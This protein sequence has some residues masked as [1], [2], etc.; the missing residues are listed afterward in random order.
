MNP[1]MDYTE[2]TLVEKPAI[3][4][5]EEL[6]WTPFNAFHEFDGGLSSLGR[7]NKSEV[8]L[9]SRLREA[10][11]VLNPDAA[12]EAIH[13]AI[14]ELSRD[15]SRLSMVAANR[16]VYELLKSGV[17]V[18]VPDPEG[19]GESVEVIRVMDWD[20]PGNNDFLVCSQFWITGEMHTRRADLVGFVNGLPLVL[21]ELKAVHRRLETAFTGN[22]RDYKDTI[23]QLFWP[24]ALV[25]LSNGSQS[26][27]GS[28]T[29]GWEHFAEWKKVDS[30]DEPARVSLETMLRGVCDPDRLLD[31]VE[32][33]TLFQEAPGGLIKLTAKNHQYLGVN[34]AI[35]ALIATLSPALSPALSQGERGKEDGENPGQKEKG[36]GHYRGGYDF[37][38]LVS[39]ARELRQL[40]TPAE[41][42]LWV[43]LR[44]KQL[45]G[46]KFRRQHQIG[47]YIVDFYCHAAKLIIE[48]DGS[49]HDVPEKQ[50]KDKKKQAYLKGLG[51]K[52][53]RIPNASILDSPHKALNLIVLHLPSPP[54]RGA[55]GEGNTAEKAKGRLGVFWHTQGSGKSVSMMFFT[56]KVLRKI[57]GN[58]TFVVVTDRLELDGQIYKHFATSGVVTESQAQAE[59]SR[60]LRQLLGEDHRFVFTIINKFRTERGE[61]HPV[62][63]ERDDIIVI[64]DEA[65]RSQYDTMALNMRT[66][67][68]KASF[69][70][71]TGTPLI[72]GEEKTRLVFGDYISVYDFQ[73]SVADG[74]T[75]PL[76]Y[77][78]RIPELQLT[79]AN[80][81]ADM[82]RLLEEAELDEAQEKKLERDFAREYHL[83]TREDRLE[84]IAKD[85]VN[86]FSSRGFRGKG[87]MIC[88]DKATAI[89]MYDKVRNHWDAK[90][91]E[92]RGELDGVNEDDRSALDEDVLTEMEQRIAWMR[93]TDMA[94]VV[95]QGQN[96]IAEMVAKGLDIKPH[97][98]RMLDEDLETRFKKPDDPLRLVF[99]CAMWITGFDVPSCSTLYLDKPMR[100]HTLMQTIARAN[101]VFFGK[102]C[103]LIVDYVGVFRNLEKALAIYGSKGSSGTDKSEDKKPVEDKSALV[104]ALRHALGETE[105]MCRSHGI[106]LDAIRAADGLNCVGLLD[107]AV[108]A[109]V[110]TEE[111]KR[112]YLDLANVVQRL[113]KAVLPDPEAKEFAAQV[114][115]IQVIAEK[116]RDLTPPADISLIMEQVEDL[117]D[118]S[119]ATEGYIIHQTHPDYGEENWVDLSGIDFDA[120][121]EKFKKGRKRTINEKLKGTLA[122]KL[123]AMLRLNP[124]RMDYLEKFQAMIDDYNK[125]SLNAEEFFHR[126]KTFAGNLTHEEQR[127]VSEQLTEEELTLFDL[128]T[129]PDIELSEKD[130]IKVKAT[131]RQLLEALKREKL[132]LDWRKRQQARAEV[133]VTIEKVLD[134]GLPRVYTP[135]LF[136]QKSSAVYQHVYDAYFGDGG[137]VYGTAA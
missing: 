122:R 14:A 45:F 40:Q 15:R 104:A 136:N 42:I 129:K 130:K 98:K 88:I 4:L 86:H 133:R 29:A 55:G 77:E 36:K 62:L 38:G 64:T 100:N 41:E 58:W 60:H 50:T 37:G 6:G 22:L 5:L 91:A 127:A 66:A 18:S 85:L 49:I 72:V 43:F 76:Y 90:I 75:V 107:D 44:S 71:F 28:I 82:E 39:R 125:G 117:L 101:R 135:E 24:N 97:R 30:E 8:I 112:G 103:G 11:L 65:H 2:D 48:V 17:R 25:I 61:T 73:Q 120:L 54:G 26:R 80:L 94:V 13:E 52:I 9:K 95:S 87:M 12:P 19:D 93:E 69:L 92:L 126:L 119:V 89:R 137:S 78:N 63:S 84:A 128:L 56:Q 47:D 114:M 35:A 115:P 53:I 116:I 23:P 20:V 51:Y 1:P 99:V 105:R 59:S 68:P 102:V 81:N 124:T 96:E 67:L 132:V 83:I 106:H 110:G 118:R 34:N 10:L 109:L 108:D 46:Y 131:A 3:A 33:F 123:M 134:A 57:P 16:E 32:N 121:A 21:F 113:Y 31:L 7:E 111:I 79:N 27:V 74:A 70:A